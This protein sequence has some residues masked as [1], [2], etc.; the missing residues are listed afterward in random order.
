MARKRLP[1]V[2]LGRAHYTQAGAL[3][4]CPLLC[5]AERSSRLGR[6]F[7]PPQPGRF[8]LATDPLQKFAEGPLWNSAG[9]GF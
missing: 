5:S 9:G 3:R 2:Y 7:Y 1:V 4:T 8:Y 6:E